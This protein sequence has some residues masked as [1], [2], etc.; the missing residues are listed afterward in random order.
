V[1][2]T[3]IHP[4]KG[5]GNN[6]QDEDRHDCHSWGNQQTVLHLISII[7]AGK[8]VIKSLAMEIRR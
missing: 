7:L 3:Y 4:A 2:D 5:H 1:Y 8:M 6:Q